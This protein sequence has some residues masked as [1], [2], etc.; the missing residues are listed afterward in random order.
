MKPATGLILLFLRISG[1]WAVTMPWKVIY[2]RPE[3]VDDPKLLTH[4]KVHIQQIE[5]DGVVTWAFKVLWYLVRYGYR[6]SP[7]EIEARRDTP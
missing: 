3:H 6:N 1:A 4:E 7:Y 2:A 5:R